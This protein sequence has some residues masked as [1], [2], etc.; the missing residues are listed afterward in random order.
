MGRRELYRDCIC[1]H[2]RIRNCFRAAA[3]STIFLLGIQSVLA[4]PAKNSNSDY[5]IVSFSFPDVVG[6]GSITVRRPIEHQFVDRLDEHFVRLATLA[7]ARGKFSLRVKK[8]ERLEFVVGHKLIDNPKLIEQ[9]DP[10]NI[11]VLQMTVMAMDNAEERKGDDFLLHIDHFQNLEELGL[12]SS[13]I[14]D[15]GVV[16]L[17]RLPKLKKLFVNDT[18]LTAKSLPLIIQIKGLEVLDLGGLNVGKMD[19]TPVSTLP[20]LTA[21]LMNNARVTDKNIAQ[22]RGCQKL[23]CLEIK[24]NPEVTDASADEL[25]SHKSLLMVHMS[26]TGI[27]T[28]TLKKLSAVPCLDVDSRLCKGLNEK[29][30]RKRYPNVRLDFSHDKNM[31]PSA[32][33]LKLFAPTRY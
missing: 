2:D 12:T 6:L 32:D 26:S 16:K 15:R 9:I 17:T 13:D 4:A 3:I 24:Q 22:L 14:G 11:K 8:G 1:S 31:N 7:Q 29:E 28:T 18:L 20:N 5:E 33:E 21:L 30:L 25:A 23:R 10:Q 27:T 19:L